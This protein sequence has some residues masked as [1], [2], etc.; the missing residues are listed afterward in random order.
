VLGFKSF[1]VHPGTA[2][3]SMVAEEDL[4]LAM[5]AIA[6]TGRPLLVHAEL[7]GPI[8]TGDGPWRRYAEYLESRPDEAETQAI[9]LMTRLC[10]E[11]RCPVH[12]VHLAT[13]KALP[14]LREARAEGLPLTA[15][16]CPHY[17]SFAAEDIPDGATQF[18]CAPPIRG[19]ANREL[20]WQALRDGI[21]DLVATDHSPCPPAMKRFEEGD[22]QKA[23]GGIASLSVAL[24]AMWSGASERGFEIGDVARWM[25]EKPAELA[26]LEGVKGRIAPG[27]D[28][29]FVVLDPDEEFLVKREDL[30]FRHAV[31]PFLGKRLK[32]R[33]KATY[34]RGRLVGEAPGRECRVSRWNSAW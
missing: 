33:V 18:K 27:C 3:F 30:H 4:R 9:K 8:K 29:D 28:A 1:L 34:V 25:A 16:T 21:I 22:F 12:I 6:R 14:A 32:G 10:R 24:S 11:F 13:A 31:S 17:L 23:W 5:P 20:L 2:E 7:P 19:A 15:E 26:G